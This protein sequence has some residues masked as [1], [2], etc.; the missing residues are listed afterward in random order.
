[1]VL[2]LG[3]GWQQPWWLRELVAGES[4][5][6]GPRRLEV[7][8]SRRWWLWELVAGDDGGDVREEEKR[9]VQ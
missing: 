8:G 1:M 4:E 6:E 2:G 3:S 7:V 9:D 5:S